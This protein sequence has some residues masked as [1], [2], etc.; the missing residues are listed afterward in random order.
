MLSWNAYW[1]FEIH[2]REG[3]VGVVPCDHNKLHDK[4]EEEKDEKD[5]RY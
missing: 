4:K 3:M 5:A 1:K 2:A